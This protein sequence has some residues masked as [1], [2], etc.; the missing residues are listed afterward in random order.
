MASF[1]N[2]LICAGLATILWTCIGFSL[3]SQLMPRS[4]AWPMAPII[5][6][7]VHS[8]LAFPVFCFVGMTR[9]AVIAVTMFS[10][11]AG[12]SASWRMLSGHSVAYSGRAAFWSVAGAAMLAAAVMAMVIPQITAGGVSLT[13]TI[14][15][16]AKVAMIDDMARLGVPA[17]NPFFG[18]S[19]GMIRLSYYYLWHFSAAEIAVL[20]GLGGWN[21]DAG[22]TWFTAFASLMLMMGLARWLSGRAVAAGWVLL[23]ATSFAIRPILSQIFGE[24]NVNAVTGWPS[25]FGAWLFQAA[26]APQHLASASCVVIAIFLLIELA[27]RQSV[28]L[29]AV[30]SLMA[31]AA[32][33]SSTWIGGVTFPLVAAAVGAL[34][35]SRLAPR[36]RRRFV[37]SVAVAGA[38]AI[39][40]ASPF[41]YDQFRASA[42]RA[43][44]APIGIKPFTVLGEE[45]PESISVWLDV[46]VY[47]TLF[48]FA[49][50]AAFYPAGIIM[51]AWLGRDR[52]LPHAQ[53]IFVAPLGLLA[54]VSLAV[55]SMLESRL[56]GN[57][58]LAWRGV[59]PAVLVLIVFTAAGLARYLRTMPRLYAVLIVGF[60]ALGCFVGIKNIYSNIGVPYNPP[61]PLFADSARMWSAV[62]KHAGDDER[63]A[64]NPLSF[65]DMTPWPINI[66]WALMANRRSCYA[67]ADYGPF[68][69]RMR[70]GRSAVDDQFKR[71]FAG[72][73]EAGDLDQLVN[74]YNCKVAVV[75]PQD[76]AWSSDPFA[77][78]PLYRL[79]E[80]EPDGWRIYRAQQSDSK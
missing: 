57:N 76:G 79:V 11:I 53:R 10:L 34:M 36:D 8:A 7:A 59:V 66:S 55:G 75:T 2:A 18:E 9:T 16:H 27:K 64:N 43:D 37:V 39:L 46:P 48:L 14:F 54:I 61:S 73:A 17:G 52:I 22:L 50:Y 74:Q 4:L 6:W 44:G 24:H 32:F 19:D 26:W 40:I 42:L 63:I 20:T 15:D 65:G 78:S 29:V 72:Q 47:W 3:S 41:I 80:A 31:A 1:Q 77:S 28:L 21:A 38:L 5:G 58:D 60:A 68:A 30:F 69:P 13:N 71:I 70:L 25:G 35:L 12:L 33:Q 67:G 49:E 45:T 62:R 23:I 51:I 56:G